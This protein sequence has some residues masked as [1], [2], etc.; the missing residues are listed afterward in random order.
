MI[1]KK[2]LSYLKSQLFG[3]S[4][5]LFSASVFNN[6]YATI[7]NITSTTFS[8]DSI[9]AGTDNGVWVWSGTG[10]TMT[11]MYTQNTTPLANT[12][13]L[14]WSTGRDTSGSAL[15]MYGWNFDNGNTLTK[16]ISGQTTDTQVTTNLGTPWA[17][18]EVNQLTG[19]IYMGSFYAGYMSA[20]AGVYRFKIA[21]FNPNTGAFKK[22]SQL[23]PATTSD[24]LT[25]GQDYVASDMA[26]DAE[27]NAYIIAGPYAVGTKYLLKVIPGEDNATWKYTK[28]ATL[29]NLPNPVNIWGMA[30]FNGELFAVAYPNQLYRI[31]V[32][33]GNSTTV[34]LT[35]SGM[36]DIR[37]LAACQ[38]A[39]VIKGKV[40]NDTTGEGNITGSEDGLS[41]IIIQLWK[42]G[43][44]YKSFVTGDTGEYSFIVDS[45]N[46][47]DYQIRV[48]QPKINNV[49]AVQTWATSDST[50]VNPV[51]AYCMLGDGTIN[52]LT[53]DG[54]CRGSGMYATDP[55]TTI[56]DGY[57]YSEVTMNSDAKVA[58]AS[59]ALT[60]A[61]NFGDAP[62]SY[63]NA[64]SPARHIA[65]GTSS[66]LNTKINWLRLGDTVAVQTAT[67]P[68]ADA[69]LIASHDGIEVSPKGE[70]NYVSLQD[71]LLVSG[72]TY[73]FRA[74]TMGPASSKG[75]LNGWIDWSSSKSSGSFGTTQIVTDQSGV[76]NGYVTFDYT[77]PAGSATS[78][79]TTYAR[80]RFSTTQ[81]LGPNNDTLPTPSATVPWVVDGE[82][83]DYRLYITPG[84]VKL[85][86]ISKGGVGAFTYSITNVSDS[87]PSSTTDSITTVTDGTKLTSNALH[88]FSA[89]NQAVVIT[90]TLPSDDWETISAECLEG[91]SS[92]SAT[93]SGNVLTIPASSV[94][95]G[96]NLSC[97]FTNGLM[98]KVKLSKSISGNR[99]NANDQF[100]VQLKDSAGSEVTSASTTGTAS[101]I[102]TS[103]TKVN[104]N[105]SSVYTLSEVMATGSVSAL[106][107]YNTE[108]SCTNSYTS[109]STTL[110]SGAGQTFNVTPNYGDNIECTLTNTSIAADPNNTN[111]TIKANPKSVTA[112]GTTESTIT[113]QLAD[114]N[115]NKLTV[116]GDK[117]EVFFTDTANKLGSINKTTQ[118]SVAATDNNDGTYTVKITSTKT[119]SDTFGFKLNDVTAPATKV[120]TVTYTAGKVD[121]TKAEITSDKESIAAD[122]TELATITVKL[123]DAQGNYLTS[124]KDPVTGKDY[125]V[126]LTIADPKGILQPTTG[127]MTNNKDGS[128]TAYVKSTQSGS[129]TI[130]FTVDDTAAND[131]VTVIYNVGAPD[132][133]SSE[134]T[135]TKPSIIADSVDSS[136]VTVTLKDKFGNQLTSGTDPS[137]SKAYN[138]VIIIKNSQPVTQST[139]TTTN[140][141]DGTFSAKV[142]SEKTGVDT[143]TFKLDDVQATASTDITYTPGKV[144]LTKTTINA[145]PKSIT[146]DGTAKSTVTVQLKDKFNNSLTTQSGTINITG[147]NIA[148][149]KADK[150]EASYIGNGKYAIE[151]SSTKSGSDSSIGFTLTDSSDV[152]TT[153]SDTTSVT[154]TAGSLDLTQSTISLSKSEIIADN[155]DSS[156][157]TIQLKDANGNNLTASGGT[158]VLVFNDGTTTKVGIDSTVTD[159]LDGSYT[160]TMKSTQTGSD[161]IGFTVAGNAASNTKVLNYTPG[162]VDLT[163]S[164]IVAKPVMIEAND[165]DTS[166]ITVQ[167]KDKYGNN[168]VT[169]EGV[170][171]LYN[172]T[173]GVVN[174][175]N[176][177]GDTLTYKGNG[178]Y[179]GTVTSTKTG[180]DTFKFKLG[181]TAG[182]KSADVT[183]KTGGPS[184]SKSTITAS[185]TSITADDVMESTITVQLKDQFENN[186]T[187]QQGNVYFVDLNTGYPSLGK[188]NIQLTY[189]ADGRYEAKIKSTKSGFDNIGYKLGESESAA[190]NGT[191]HVTVTYTAGDIDFSKSTIVAIPAA[192]TANDVTKSTITVQLKDKFSNNI[193]TDQGAMVLSDLTIGKPNKADSSLTYQTDGT[194][195]ATVTSVKTGTDATIGFTLTGKG[196]GSDTTSITY[197]P[198]PVNLAKSEISA[199]PTSI[200]ANYSD[201]STVT[202][203]FKDAYGNNLSGDVTGTVALTDVTT[204]EVKTALKS[205]GNGAYQATVY[206]K[207]AG[208]DDIKFTLDGAQGGTGT[209]AKATV[210]YTPGAADLTQSDLSVNPA[211]IVANGVTTSKI[212]L[213]LKD[214]NGN[215]LTAGS[216]KEVKIFISSS[217]I[218]GTIDRLSNFTNVGDGTYTATVKSK[219][220]GTDT[221]TFSID[222][223]ASTTEKTVTYT[224]GAASAKDSI[225]SATPSSIVAD[226]TA[227]SVVTVQLRDKNGNN[228]TSS[229][230]K[231]VSISSPEIGI[232]VGTA[233]QDNSNGTYSITVKSK[234]TGTDTFT[235]SVLGTPNITNNATVT[236]TPG[237][238]DLSQST[239]VASPDTIIADGVEKTTVTVQLKDKFKNNL[240]TNV[241]KVELTGVNKA[242][243]GNIELDYNTGSTGSYSGTLSSTDNGSDSINFKL[244]NVSSTATP[245]T[246]TYKSGGASLVKSTIDITPSSITANGTDVATVTIQLK[247]KNDN[248]TDNGEIVTLTGIGTNASDDYVGQ[249]VSFSKSTNGK[250]VGTVKSTKSGYDTIS[251]KIDDVQSQ[252][253]KTVTYVAGPASTT[254]SVL[255]VTPSTITADNGVTKATVSVQLKDANGNNVIGAVSDA[256]TLVMPTPA[257]GLSDNL[258]MSYNTSTGVYTTEVYS[259]QTGTDLLKYKLGT[260]VGDDSKNITYTAG[261]VSLT[262]SIITATP[263]SITANGTDLS[264]ISVQLKDQYGNNLNSNPGA[265]TLLNLKT[266]K[267]DAAMAYKGNGRY[268]A[269]ISSE[270]SGSDTLGYTIAQVGDGT[271]TNSKATVTYVPGAVSLSESLISA[272]PKAVVADDT[273]TSLITVQLK[274]AKGNSI[275]TNQGTVII[276]GVDK[277]QIVDGGGTNKD[278]MSYIGDGKYQVKVKS[279]VAGP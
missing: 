12:I 106:A 196:S 146:A 13:A 237:A 202:I 161:T 215:P 163:Q 82:V 47:Q 44:W 94:K 188:T 268:E 272:S 206:S 158:V 87:S 164:T 21:V 236:Y 57:I 229:I 209:T 70:T 192:I 102:A 84:S 166:T 176:S 275:L 22:S 178:Y 147:V 2:L 243:E 42:G 96:A 241:G 25:S 108:M 129:D 255:T 179:E 75:Y 267:L 8:C 258:T 71:A 59:F 34:T 103:A 171:T 169:N 83:E 131:T 137:T 220:S 69:N 212:T 184:L 113:I 273:T 187:T 45:T 246:V 235:F 81:G 51:T 111:T 266:G 172:Y 205:I 193:T 262:E 157:V 154:Y 98:P 66:S 174:K 143:F 165:S 93:L 144:D 153:G 6:A 55:I 149:Q 216:D 175:G 170:V 214:A 257:F 173:Y 63:N 110:P 277:T 122:D 41:G 23:V 27:G 46:K 56:K 19:E 234:K 224:A 238:V 52:K 203:Q 78:L 30:F 116:G 32:L 104:G 48:M 228:L 95:E 247:D 274:D 40:Y 211:S 61:S 65:P 38:V 276:T 88:A 26:I 11:K 91:T 191:D 101:S 223:V 5:L 181:E 254:Q 114:S 244:D 72:N 18:G 3:L 210:T 182:T 213:T 100:T 31:N 133:G 160:A 121:T 15:T 151:L 112:D 14:G 259:K 217:T 248:N 279:K 264:V 67:Q 64:T 260:N 197:T 141:G 251:F 120:A 7:S 74:K 155:T 265:V 207:K 201:V 142:T 127:L 29:N 118:D 36:G 92:V 28:V 79:H 124:G 4:I 167:L 227:T 208:S 186:I 126:K 53:S 230:G 177:N 222:N 263:D 105:G 198:G 190:E 89:L 240:T 199:T 130:G 221:I 80:F 140:N 138:L 107:R 168:L 253:N 97:T 60:T 50:S 135:A 62:S 76:N 73:T 162:A 54:P 90:Q 204:G 10:G 119:G 242:T 77:V 249:L 43:T 239:I 85:S 200:T 245:V 232:M 117:V 150:I 261:P 250:W 115:G 16:L 37:D 180:T 134:I 233:V 33:T 39:P 183:Y 132:I 226:D 35:G 219:I 231:A 145:E 185:N 159:N 68:S 136:T 99:F 270:V 256:V 156:I 20:P 194:Y 269:K 109:S 218:S 252:N 58:N 49:N 271:G 1:T 139:I 17:G 86:A 195:T 189:V 125:T 123:K 24:A 148:T 225:I 9:Y 128:F 278:E 152:T